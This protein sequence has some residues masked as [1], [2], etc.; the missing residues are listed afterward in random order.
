MYI[1]KLK[2]N[3]SDNTFR[4]IE[5]VAE[6]Y[7]VSPMKMRKLLIT[8][9]VY[10]N[11]TSEFIGRLWEEGKTIHEI[12]SITGLSKSSVNG[13]LP[14]S[15]VI[16]KN[17]DSSVGA[18]RIRLFRARRKACEELQGSLEEKKLWECMI[19]YQNFKFYTASGL[20]FRYF[21][22]I[23]KNGNLTKELII[24]RRS[25][26]KTLTWSSITI[27]FRNAIRMQGTIIEKPKSL[28]DI[29]GISYIYPMLYK[30]GVINVPETVAKHMDNKI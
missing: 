29:R 17:Q 12:Q 28:G 8:S 7:S 25:E 2:E 18:D 30:F 14:Y 1:D 24:D 15:K 9:G 27:A 5:D 23:G 20:P 16:Y 19:L 11:E 22:K 3:S 13:Y 10:G 6:E 4:V 21:I 26:S